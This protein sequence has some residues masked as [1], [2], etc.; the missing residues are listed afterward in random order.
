MGTRI[1]RNHRPKR[2]EKKKERANAEG[3]GGTERDVVRGKR[4][5]KS[6]GST[7][8]R[9]VE[10]RGRADEERARHWEIRLF[11]VTLPHGSRAVSAGISKRAPEPQTPSPHW[12]REGG[13]EMN[14]KE[15]RNRKRR[16]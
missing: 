16:R 3:K 4:T 13:L 5:K 8:S 1:A 10:A 12:P 7:V 14:Q 15:K 2:V 6:L 11:R 9:R